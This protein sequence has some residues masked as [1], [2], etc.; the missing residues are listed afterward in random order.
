MTRRCLATRHPQCRGC[1]DHDARRRPPRGQPLCRALDACLRR[2]RRIA[3]RRALYARR[4]RRC[5]AFDARRWRPRGQAAPRGL[6]LR[7][8]HEA[9]WRWLRK[10]PISRYSMPACCRVAVRAAA[11][12]GDAVF[13]RAGMFC[14]SSFCERDIFV[15]LECFAVHGAACASAR[16]R[17]RCWCCARGVLLRAGLL[18]IERVAACSVAA[19]CESALCR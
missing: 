2:P 16:C 18:V 10:Q 17:V 11:A 19:V 6:T 15:A 14:L 9:R 13:L 5:R 8:A 4:R 7:R 1:R 3:V 12:V